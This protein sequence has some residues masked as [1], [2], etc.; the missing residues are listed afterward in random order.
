MKKL[1]L[2]LTIFCLIFTIS[3]C[4]Q[5]TSDLYPNERLAIE[6]IRE[7]NANGGNYDGEKLIVGYNNE[8]SFTDSTVSFVYMPKYK[9]IYYNGEFYSN[10]EC[11]KICKD[12][13]NELKRIDMD[14]YDDIE[15]YFEDYDAIK[16]QITNKEWDIY[17]IYARCVCG[18]E[19][20]EDIFNS[21]ITIV[22]Y[23]DIK[24]YI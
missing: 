7:F 23:E 10:D 17:E 18:Y 6:A 3:G 16:E 8:N 9:N 5:N 14:D 24:Q 4:K 21:S 19:I 11:D 13:N 15:K 1:L 12:I 20:G 2:C 22:E